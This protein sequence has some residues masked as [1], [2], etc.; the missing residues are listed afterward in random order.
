MLMNLSP[1]V[2][3][4]SSLNLSPNV[5]ADSPMYSSSHSMLVHLYLYISPLFCV[6]TVFLFALLYFVYWSAFLCCGSALFFGLFLDMLLQWLHLVQLPQNFLCA[7]PCSGWCDVL[8]YLYFLYFFAD[9]ILLSHVFGHILIYVL[10]FLSYKS[11]VSF[12][13]PNIDFSEWCASV[14]SAKDKA[15]WLVK[16]QSSHVFTVKNM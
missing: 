16:E 4:D 9:W 13:L 12:K 6:L 5:L 2:L 3:A 1:N 14:L 15:W 8:Q 11:L 10:N 7:R